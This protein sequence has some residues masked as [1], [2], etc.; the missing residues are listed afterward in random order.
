MTLKTTDLRRVCQSLAERKRT[1]LVTNTR[2]DTGMKKEAELR[3]PSFFQQ[4]AQNVEISAKYP[5][6]HLATSPYIVVLVSV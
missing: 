6:D 5:S 1:L 4:L 2:A 3:P